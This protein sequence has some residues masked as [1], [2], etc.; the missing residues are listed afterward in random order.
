MHQDNVAFN[1]GTTHYNGQTIDT[2]DYGNSVA[3]EGVIH[4][5]PSIDT[6]V[7]ALQ[8]RRAGNV[9]MIC[10]RNVSGINLLPG[11]I[12]LW[13]AGQE[14]KRVDGMCR[15]GAAAVARVAGVVDDMLP[16]AG[17]P[18]GDLFWMAVKGKHLAK[19]GLAI[20]AIVVGDSVVAATAASTQAASAGRINLADFN[21]AT[22]PLAL[23][24]RGVVGVALTAR[25]ANETYTD[26]LIDLDIE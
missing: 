2:N 5:F 17:V 11:R 24:I 20:S 9:K 19:T 16:A 10:V 25:T 23:A 22:T 26:I 1:R 15:L 3:L 14:G 13:K 6:S 18:N 12:C 21:Q 8:S 7:T 4:E